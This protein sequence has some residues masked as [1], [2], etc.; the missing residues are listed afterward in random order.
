MPDV[1]DDH[2]LAIDAVVNTVCRSS[3]PKRIQ[4]APVGFPPTARVV[5]ERPYSS[6]DPANYSSSGL[7]ASLIKI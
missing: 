1:D 2:F 4:V 5:F 6:N 7:R 3:H